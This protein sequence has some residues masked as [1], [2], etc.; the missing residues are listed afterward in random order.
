MSLNQLYFKNVCSNLR[1]HIFT[2]AS[3]EAMCILAYL[4]DDAT[5]KLTYV[6]GKCR[7]A[8]KRRTTIPILELQAA[9][10][11]VRLRRQIMRDHV[12]R[13]DKIY[14]FTDSSTVLQWLQSA[15]RKQ[16]VFVANRAAEILENSSMDQWIHV[17][18]V[19]NPADIGARGMSIEGFKNSG[20]LKG[21]AWLQTDE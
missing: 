6:I 12:V 1:L 19:G 20:W 8:P 3:V 10:N 18:G 5:L 16:Q 14:H 13:N 11:G 21:P 15:H 9:V 4:Q 2:D 17:K 7:V